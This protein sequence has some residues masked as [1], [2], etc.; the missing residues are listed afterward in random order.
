MSAHFLTRWVSRLLG[1]ALV[2]WASARVGVHRPIPFAFH[3]SVFFSIHS[4]SSAT[5]FHSCFFFTTDVSAP[6]QSTLTHKYMNSETS[7]NTNVFV[8]YTRTKTRMIETNLRTT[9]SMNSSIRA[10]YWLPRTLLCLRPMY[11]G[12]SSRRWNRKTTTIAPRTRCSS[13]FYQQSNS[14]P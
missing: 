14:S 2:S 4:F 13:T 9:D 7:T 10:S 8:A 6:I 3:I 11:I 5:G 1:L 12:S